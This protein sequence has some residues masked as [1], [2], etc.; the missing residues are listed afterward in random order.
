[1]SSQAFPNQ[2]FAFRSLGNLAT[3]PRSFDNFP[4]G[5][6]LFNLLYSL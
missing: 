1:M 5:L 6:T 2:A 4:Q 3:N